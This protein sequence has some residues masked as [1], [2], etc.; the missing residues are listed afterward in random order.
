MAKPSEGLKELKQLRAITGKI[1]KHMED[2]PGY[3]TR[4]WEDD[5]PVREPGLGKAEILA[6]MTGPEN[7]TRLV[8]AALR[9]LDAGHLGLTRAL[10]I[11][12]DAQE[13]VRR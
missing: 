8:D 3:Q 7:V 11:L 13:G 10:L 4:W 9:H 5:L 12:L 2:K 1:L 6:S